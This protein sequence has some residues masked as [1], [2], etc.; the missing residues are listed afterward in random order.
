MPATSILWTSKKAP[1]TTTRF[2][3]ASPSEYSAPE[4]PPRN[5]TRLRPRILHPCDR[6]SLK[7]TA[8]HHD[9]GER[10][11]DKKAHLDQVDNQ[12]GPARNDQVL[13]GLPLEEHRPQEVA[14]G[15]HWRTRHQPAVP[16]AVADRDREHPPRRRVRAA[17]ARNT[18]R[19]LGG[20]YSCVIAISASPQGEA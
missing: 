13:R 11:G 17:A 12:E 15:L 9:H 5:R 8:P 10:A 3:T 6:R 16:V 14:L 4:K 18:G 19:S 1:P 7:P 20:C 2:V